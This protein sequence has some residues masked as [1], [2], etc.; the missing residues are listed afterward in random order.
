[1]LRTEYRSG[2]AQAQGILST[3]SY[4]SK[5]H[6]GNPSAEEYFRRDQAAEFSR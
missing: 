1:M 5:E 4:F 6:Q 2:H 3:L